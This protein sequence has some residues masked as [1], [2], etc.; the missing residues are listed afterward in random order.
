MTKARSPSGPNSSLTQALGVAM[1]GTLAR[2]QLCQEVLPKVGRLSAGNIMGPFTQVISAT[3]TLHPQRNHQVP[4]LGIKLGATRWNRPPS[5]TGPPA[6]AATVCRLSLKHSNLQ[7][8]EM[9]SHL[10]FG[11]CCDRSPNGMCVCLKSWRVSESCG[12]HHVSQSQQWFIHLLVNIF[13][14]KTSRLVHH[15]TKHSCW[16]I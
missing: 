2:A 3:T 16:V 6:S 9:T 14:V 7:Q 15:G 11:F 12:G 1:S 5:V 13:N 10:I 8:F 4:V